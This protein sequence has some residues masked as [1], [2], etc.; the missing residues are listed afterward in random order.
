MI[1]TSIV[2]FSL[3]TCRLVLR[4]RCDADNAQCPLGKKFGC[5]PSDGQYLLKVA[6]SLNLDVVGI[7]FHVGSGCADFPIYYKAIGL[8]KELFDY[9]ETIGYS[10][11]LL[12][13]G[14]GFPGDNDKTI[15]D[16]AVIVNKALDDYFPDKSVKII[17]EPGRYYVASA[18]TLVTN[19][20]SRKI[21]KK[22]GNEKIERMMYYIND[23][24]Y[25]SFNC[26]LYDHQIVKPIL[27]TPPAKSETKYKSIILG[28]TCDAL[29]Q[30]LDNIEMPELQIGDYI[31]FENMGAYT[32]PVA[33][34]FNGFALPKVHCFISL[35]IWETL[36]SL[37]PL[38]DDYFIKPLTTDNIICKTFENAVYGWNYD[39]FNFAISLVEF[40]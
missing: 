38:N 40:I 33:S 14:G 18:F 34:P 1:Y 20:H 27:L 2:I 39:I 8:C 21:V 4:I 30:L 36:K 37:I 16:V 5:E 23:G 10:L 29:D 9:A 35:E 13:I 22:P 11:N 28:P 24:V 12:D 17:A 7:S 15:D 19:I 26:I 32:I 31:V 25:G 6:Q 3:F